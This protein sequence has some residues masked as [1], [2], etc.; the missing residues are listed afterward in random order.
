LTILVGD[1]HIAT[2][3]LDTNDFSLCFFSPFVVV[4]ALIRTVSAGAQLEFRNGLSSWIDETGAYSFVREAAE[5][6]GKG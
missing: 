4:D 2:D 1:P 6:C 5:E 3:G